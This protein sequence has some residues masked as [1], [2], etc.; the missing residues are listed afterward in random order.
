MT[1]K[2]TILSRTGIALALILVLGLL[3]PTSGAAGSPVSPSVAPEPDGNAVVQWNRTAAEAALRPIVA[4]D[5]NPLHESRMYAMMHIAIHDA[6]NAIKHRS[7][8]YVFKGHA[9]HA[10]PEAAVASA[11]RTTLVNALVGADLRPLPNSAHGAIAG[12]EAAYTAALAAIPEGQAKARGISLG[13]QAAYAILADRAADGSDTP[14]I[15]ADFPQGDEPGE[16]RF[17]PGYRPLPSRRNGAK[18][19]RLYF[20]RL[21]NSGSIRPS[22]SIP[23]SMPTTSTRCS[24][25]AATTSTTP[26]D[27]TDEETEIARFWVESSPL[28]WNRIARQLATDRKLNLWQS[29]RL[30]GLLDIALSDGYIAT[31]AKKYDLLFWRP[32]T[33]IQLAGTDGNAATVADPTWTP[34]VTTPPVPDHDSGHSVEGGAASAVLRGFFRT[35]DIEFS[36]CSYTA[37]GRGQVYGCLAGGSALHQLLRGREGERPLPGPGRLPLHARNHGGHPARREDRQS[38]RPEESSAATSLKAAGRPGAKA[39]LG[40][41]L[42]V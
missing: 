31:F 28:L 23:R 13:R 25:W 36:T 21:I 11:A 26:S 27:R 42:E 1:G 41:L 37:A 29:A 4:P 7:R 12:V 16:Y 33:A 8:P 10:S 5:D 40:V 18:S 24:G 9:H 3:A 34:L 15:V 6:L 30:F 22:P 39:L 17:T 35:D 32:V 2:K 38:D 20:G 14:L 19:T